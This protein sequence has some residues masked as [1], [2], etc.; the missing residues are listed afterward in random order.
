MGAYSPAP[1]LP[2]SDYE[3]TANLVIR[4]IIRA[5]S[6]A[7]SPF[8]GVLY[9]GLMYTPEGPMVLEYNVR[10][11][12]PECQ[13][14]MAR[15]DSDLA[16]LMMAC[17]EG[18]LAEVRAEWKDDTGICVVMAADGYPGKYPKGME[19]SGLDEAEDVPGVTVFQAGTKLEGGK[20]VSSGGRILGVTALGTDLADAGD[21]A[22]RAVEKINFENSYYRRDIGEKGL[23]R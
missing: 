17:V 22:Y 8:A 15:L 14:L 21:K 7:G 20:I 2:E 18:R 5:L 9:A 19:I 16:E 3:K 11:G 23:K 6:E 12:D 1:I 13:P 4:P 10:F